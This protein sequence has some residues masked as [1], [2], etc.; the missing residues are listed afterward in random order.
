MLHESEGGGLTHGSEGAEEG[1]DMNPAHNW[2]A[3]SGRLMQPVGPRTLEQHHH[4]PTICNASGPVRR[5]FSSAGCDWEWVLGTVLDARNVLPSDRARIC[6][7]QL[8]SPHSAAPAAAGSASRPAAP[9]R[10]RADLEERASTR[11]NRGSYAKFPKQF[12]RALL[13]FLGPECSWAGNFA[14]DYDGD[15]EEAPHLPRLLLGA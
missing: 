14:R 3:T 9:A 2:S 12:I 5:I 13:G 15:H 10:A 11:A 8:P 4:L 7:V 6:E 1:L